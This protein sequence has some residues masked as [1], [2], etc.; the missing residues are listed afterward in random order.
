MVAPLLKIKA[1]EKAYIK[2]TLDDEKAIRQV[3]S[4][5]E[6]GGDKS[7]LIY[8]YYYAGTVYRDLGDVPQALEY[9]QKSERRVVEG[10]D[11]TFL[12]VMY[13]QTGHLYFNEDLSKEAMG[14]F[15]KYKDLSE[16]MGDKRLMLYAY[17]Y[18]AKAYA[19]I[20]KSDSTIYFKNKALDIALKTGGNGADEYNQL[21]ISYIV[22]EDYDKAGEMLRKREET[23]DDCA[24]D[25]VYLMPKMRY[26]LHE[27]QLDEAKKA[28]LA[29]LET[30]DVTIYDKQYVYQALTEIEIKRRNYELAGKY[31]R[32]HEVYDDSISRLH[33]AHN[34][35]RMNA[36]YN[37]KLR[38]NENREVKERNAEYKMCITAFI[39]AFVLVLVGLSLFFWQKRYALRFHFKL[40]KEEREE[41]TNN[42][43]APLSQI[44]YESGMKQRIE[45]ILAEKAVAD[46]DLW[47]ALELLFTNNYPELLSSIRQLYKPSEFEKQIC[48]LTALEVQ[49]KDIATLTNRTDS[50]VSVGKKRLYWKLFRKTGNAS[51]F[52]F[53]IAS[54]VY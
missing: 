35:A 28:A 11:S 4:H 44:Y 42:K 41:R 49:N 8:A 10:T 45:N 38:E 13:F 33:S 27:G 7:K 51:D 19:Y 36:I 20:G 29:V 54:I 6:E 52:D 22:K 39:V 3:V 43:R 48:M 14:Y 25:G 30:E 32:L 1:R 46:D 2:H 5:Y 16:K 34:L 53:F 9:F 15:K 37:Y 47:C 12:A 18:I 31:C 21:A 40:L 26:C 24:H 17:N 50:A 23:G